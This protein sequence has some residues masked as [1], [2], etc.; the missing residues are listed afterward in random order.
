MDFG[1]N[2]T[3]KTPDGLLY[4]DLDFHP[5]TPVN[6]VL[7]PGSGRYPEIPTV[8]TDLQQI[9][10]TAMEELGKIDKV[11]LVGLTKSIAD[12]MKGLRA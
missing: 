10:D 12:A 5:G 8:Q 2:S 11:D 4:V 6:F 9:Q 3:R 7:E 1:P